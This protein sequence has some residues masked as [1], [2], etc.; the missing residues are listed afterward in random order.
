MQEQ[1]SLNFAETNKLK[2]FSSTHN[3]KKFQFPLKLHIATN[4][5]ESQYLEVHGEEMN[6]HLKYR[7]DVAQNSPPIKPKKFLTN[8][9]HEHKALGRRLR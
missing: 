7:Y 1:N 3:T 4:Q 8:P 6:G 2:K 5:K 9:L